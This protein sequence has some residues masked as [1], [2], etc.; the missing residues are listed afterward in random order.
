MSVDRDIAHEQVSGSTT[1]QL[2]SRQAELEA[3]LIQRGGLPP[4]KLAELHQIWSELYCRASGIKSE[5]WL[6]HVGIGGAV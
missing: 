2:R 1:E 5:P 3:T 6:T 4:E